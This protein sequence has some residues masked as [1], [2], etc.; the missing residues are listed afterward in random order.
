MKE[1]FNDMDNNSRDEAQNIHIFFDD[2]GWDKIETLL[3]EDDRK[4]LAALSVA[5][6]VSP[7]SR[8]FIKDNFNLPGH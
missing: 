4:P 5:P 7:K 1:L 6:A 8:F 3:N 2:N